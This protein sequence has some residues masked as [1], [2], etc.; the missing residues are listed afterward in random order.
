LGRSFVGALVRARHVRTSAFSLALLLAVGCRDVPPEERRPILELAADTI[1]LPAGVSLHEI[2]LRQRNAGS[3][4]EPQRTVA[5]VGD[6]LRFV[7]TDARG[8]SVRFDRARLPG[9]A[10]AFLAETQQLS[11]PPLL[12]GGSAWVVNLDGAP[13][14]EYVFVSANQGAEGVVVVEP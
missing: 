12:G 11:S 10:A 3:E 13:A 2:R 7:A 4:I 1:E 6:V 14:G 9:E 8:Y 5:R